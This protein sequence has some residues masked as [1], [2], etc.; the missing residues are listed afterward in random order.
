MKQYIILASLLANSLL[1]YAQK[2][3]TVEDI[4]SKGTFRSQSVY[5]INWMNDGSY[6]SALENNNIVKYDVTKGEQVEIILDASTLEIEIRISSYK[7]SA[8]EKYLLLLT[9]RQSIFRR[10]YT[11]IFY[12]YNRETKLLQKL[13]EDRIAY[14]TVSPDGS[15]VAYTK[16]NDLYY[17]SLAD[18][19]AVQVT[20]DGKRNSI[21]NGSTDWVYEEELSFTKAF[22][23]SPDSKKLAYYRFDES[24]VPEY[25]LQKWNQGATYPEN[26]TYKYPKAG[27][28]NSVIQILVYH[29]GS[30]KKTN[31]DIGIEK[32]IYIPRISW[33][34]DTNVLSVR[35][36]NR[37]QN[38]LDILHANAS[39]GK[40]TLILQDK[41][42]TYVDLELTD[43]L[44]YLNDGKHILLASEK[45]G[46]KQLYLYTIE[47]KL[48]RQITHGNWEVSTF[49]GIDQASKHKTI[50]F[51]SKEESPLETYFYAI[52]LS[53]KNKRKLSVHT[54]SNRVNMSND[55]KYYINYFS[56]ST[57]PNTVELYSTKG[58][59]MVKELENNA[60][61]KVVA[62]EY[63]LVTK[64][65]YTF[66]N[67]NGDELNGYMLK[68]NDFNPNKKYPVLMYQYSGPGSQQVSNSWGGSNGY[69]HQ[70]LVQKGYIISVVDGRGTGGRGEKFKKQTYRN[71]GRMEVEDQIAS[72]KY[73]GGLPYIDAARIGIWGWSYGGYMSSLALE[74]GA[75]VFAMAIAVA[76]VTSWRYYDTIYTERF[77]STP[78][79]NPK[80]YDNNSPVTH[81]SKMKGKF[82]LIHGTGDDNVHFQNAVALQNKL[83]SEGI[84]FES[85][86]YPDRA[87]GIY[88][89]N[90]RP[91]LFNMMTQFVLD[92]L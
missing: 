81:A 86:Y 42:D 46:Y 83:I 20:N 27:E 12:L 64:E 10:S 33:T 73:L 78:Q 17:V 15:K 21:I 26:Y 29:L 23:W 36:M 50:Y 37:L 39:T 38:Q 72:A 4:Y 66:K 13:D 65:F 84:Q 16:N 40:T 25:T 57:T 49:V 28:K 63:G 52:D 22:F 43:D 55:F 48:V 90:A 6:Y 91:H 60:K 76:P 59:K 19:Q 80:G 58:N 9:D 61:L 41:S 30:K 69:W 88:R 62:K 67:K 53:G 89:N 77:L 2:Q 8:D 54:G 5:G 85:F 71:L 68:P 75:D 92:N 11:A 31:I 34:F 74:E 87:H 45:S 3:I 79:D 14:A 7:F 32:D 56:N 47:G 70:M 44:T 18:M 24:E 82:L 1:G 51:T 35:R